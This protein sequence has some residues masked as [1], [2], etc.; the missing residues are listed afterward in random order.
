M[1]TVEQCPVCQ[2]TQRDRWPERGFAPIM[3]T[4]AMEIS[5]LLVVVAS[6]YYECMECGVVYQNPRPSNDEL[7]KFYSTGAYRMSL[8]ISPEQ[9]DT[10]EYLRS[11]R[12][13]ATLREYGIS[14]DKHLDVGCSRGYLLEQVNAQKQ[15][16]VELNKD[17]VTWNNVSK[18]VQVHSDIS[19]VR[20]KFDL[21]TCVH[22]LEH[23]PFPLVLLNEM[24]S[25]L[26]DDGTLYV[27]V[28]SEVSK[29]GPLRL[30]H[31]FF[32][33][34]GPLVQIAKTAGFHS[35]K[36]TVADWNHGIIFRKGDK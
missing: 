33:R 12:V 3:R 11:T 7:Y 13:N 34:A 4:D 29:G 31:L 19:E 32:F 26:T 22:V 21:I 28:P 36:F 17:Y 20:G 24:H 15:V 25:R 30:A 5:G 35:P 23:V 9:I 6:T 16:G 14:P 1:I 27:E 10:D 18:Q 8:G 2:S